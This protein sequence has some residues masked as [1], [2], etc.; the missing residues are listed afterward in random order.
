MA[1]FSLDNYIVSKYI[2]ILVDLQMSFRRSYLG[3]WLF[4]E[5]LI[6]HLESVS[7]RF[8]YFLE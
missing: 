8:M 7:E 3:G 1:S 6:N 5:S 4:S 2:T